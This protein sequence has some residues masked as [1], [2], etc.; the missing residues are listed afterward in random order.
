MLEDYKS[1]IS[2]FAERTIVS[3][4]ANVDW[5]EGITWDEKIVSV[6]PDAAGVD[7]NTVG[8]CKVVYHI[9]GDDNET[10]IIEEVKVF[11]I[12]A[13]GMPGE[14]ASA[15]GIG[16]SSGSN[17]TSRNTARL[18]EEGLEVQEILVV[19]GFQDSHGKEIRLEKDI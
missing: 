19:D 4:T 10:E 15:T 14:T 11:V 18:K 1:H 12:E 2:G 8:E 13:Y 9:L 3:G 16:K 5:L 17:S 6:T 7:L